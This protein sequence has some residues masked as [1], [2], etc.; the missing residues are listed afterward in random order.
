VAV[1][2][3][4]FEQEPFPLKN[5]VRRNETATITKRLRMITAATTTASSTLMSTTEK[6]PPQMSHR[7]EPL[8]A[9]RA[10][11][12]HHARHTC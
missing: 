9:S 6:M 7:H 2:F 3:A 8:A 1:G 4:L 12:S 10:F 5:A 11:S